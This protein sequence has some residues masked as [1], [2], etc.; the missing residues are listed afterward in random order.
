MNH[1]SGT[2]NTR[3]TLSIDHP[4]L[5][6]KKIEC[7]LNSM[8]FEW[9]STTFRSVTVIVPSFFRSSLAPWNRISRRKER[10]RDG[11]PILLQ[12]CYVAA[13]VAR[14]NHPPS[15]V[16]RSTLRHVSA[17]FLIMRACLISSCSYLFY[18]YALDT[19]PRWYTRPIASLSVKLCI[20]TGRFNTSP[21]FGWQQKSWSGH[22]T[23]IQVALM[24]ITCEGSW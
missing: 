10:D 8:I 21:I 12:I 11:N 18:S 17:S 3:S 9:Y 1:R 16:L 23:C 2:N 7:R 14:F 22:V 6:R 4:R 24:A 15:P 13:V 20:Q 19:D 5:R